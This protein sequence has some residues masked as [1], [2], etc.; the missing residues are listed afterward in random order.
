MNNK[1]II[2]DQ[3][4]L[5]ESPLLFLK[6]DCDVSSIS[7]ENL[8]IVEWNEY[9]PDIFENPLKLNTFIHLFPSIL[10]S[11]NLINK[12]ISS[13]TAQT[14]TG[15]VHAFNQLNNVSKVFPNILRINTIL[16]EQN[17]IKEEITTLIAYQLKLK[18]ITENSLYITK[19]DLLAKLQKELANLQPKFEIEKDE[20]SVYADRMQ[21]YLKK[22]NDYNSIQK[23]LKEEQRVLFRQTNEITKMMDERDPSM[24]TYLD[25][26][27]D[28]DPELQAED[29]KRIQKKYNTLK[30]EYDKLKSHRNSIMN[31]SKGIKQRLLKSRNEFKQ[32]NKE[33]R[34]FQPQFQEIEAKFLSLRSQIESLQ[35]QIQEIET[36]LNLMVD[37]GKSSS[38]NIDLSLDH[39]PYT[40]LAQVEELLMQKKQRQNLIL[41][42]LDEIFHSTESSTISKDIENRIS[43]MEDILKNIS[44][45]VSEFEKN[46]KI[47]TLF[48]SYIHTLKSL[49]NFMNLLLEPMDFQINFSNSIEGESNEDLKVN[50]ILKNK[51]GVET[52]L[53]ELKR[54]EKAYLILTLIVSCYLTLGISL[55]P[56]E[57][58][59]LPP[60]I[61]TK[62][63]FI[64]AT[65]LLSE[66]IL[67]LPLEEAIHVVFFME[68][69]NFDV[70]PTIDLSNK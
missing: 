63:T 70:S 43:K 14:W 39:I 25:K 56:I 42:K 8:K 67:L 30:V 1:I 55:I 45:S 47:D 12:E 46:D 18:E 51:K 41:S 50:L 69:T 36:E 11:S 4:I 28:L 64:K 31:E 15:V 61:V 38:S 5:I 52:N 6:G 54:V 49:Q 33:L 26:L 53:E 27:A 21:N 2:N 37:S 40:S 10:S 35:K 66:Q 57:F 58:K 19:K 62:Q 24:Q 9:F 48:R 34:S 23:S 20:Y 60:S 22:K 17:T 68:Q 65:Q 13:S 3:A 7:G 29:Y 59:S 16:A 44:S 32:S